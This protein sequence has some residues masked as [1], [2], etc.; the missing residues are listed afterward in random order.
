MLSFSFR[1][2]GLLIHCRSRFPGAV[3]SP[4]TTSLDFLL[5][6]TLSPIP[7]F[8]VM[9]SDGDIVDE[10]R[11][12]PEMADEQVLTWYRNMLTGWLPTVIS[13]NRGS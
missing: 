9:N 1:I 12:R 6:S 13:E 5:P 8:R 11:S 7:T 10:S 2:R 3:G 4:L